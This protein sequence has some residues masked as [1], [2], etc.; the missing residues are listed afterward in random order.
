MLDR[1]KYFLN[2]SPFYYKHFNVP[3]NNFRFRIRNLGMILRKYGWKKDKTVEGNT[4]FFVFD[5]DVPWK[6]PGLADRLKVAVCACYMSKQ[7]GFDFK[8][9]FENP[10]RLN[11]YYRIGG[12][13]SKAASF[14]DLSY[15]LRNSRLLPFNGQD[16]IPVLDKKIHQ[17]HIYICYGQDLL[18]CNHVPDW[19][20]VWG[21]CFRELFSPS[22]KLLAAYSATGLRPREYNCAHLRFV[23]ALEHFEDGVYN[24]TGEE[25]KRMLI[26]SCLGE[27]GR[28]SGESDKPLYVFSDSAL[29]LEEARKHGF[30]T[31]EGKVGHVSYHNDDETVLKTFTDFYAMSQA[32]KVY[33]II[34]PG[35]YGTTF[36]MY[37]AFAGGAEF[38][39]RVPGNY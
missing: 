2:N 29:F 19:P 3:V 10:F 20:K 37:S 4:V 25:Q 35:M 33:R 18:E 9:I 31:L 17:Y 27:L 21:E 26:D 23:N 32:A 13:G 6:Y 28:I 30:N 5:P 12:D 15:S 1:I 16:R 24:E 14:N 36:S 38:E 7:N 34:A 22:E 39:T 11:D 8:L